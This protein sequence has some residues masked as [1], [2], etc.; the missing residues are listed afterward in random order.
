MA[1]T[2][3]D[4]RGVTVT[5]ERPAQRVVSLVPSTTESLF[6]LGVPPVGVTRFCIHP[7]A[8]KQLPKV[9]GT[10]D[11]V[12]ER[13][14]ALQPDL[15]LANAEENTREIIAEIEGAG[16]PLVVAFPKDVDGALMDL[17]RIGALIGRDGSGWEAD[18]REAQAQVPTLR[19]RFLYLIWREPWMAVGPDTF[20]SRLLEDLGLENAVQGEQ[21]YPVVDPFAVQADVVLLS[22][23][24]F[25]FKAR[26]LAELQGAARS[27]CLIDGEACSWHG[28]AMLRGFRELARWAGDLGAEAVPLGA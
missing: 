20:I 2:V 18:I 10:K 9:G 21:R 13:I 4:D 14:Q 3:V 8:A 24:P 26:H 22:S 28:T 15:V 5:L 19:G 6:D 1:I 17:L 27:V 23:E 16:I 25:P 7:P 11:A 12:L